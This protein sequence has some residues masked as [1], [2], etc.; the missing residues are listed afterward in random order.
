MLETIDNLEGV[1]RAIDLTSGAQR[2]A[3]TPPLRP[4]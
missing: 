4:S 2:Y 3:M 1:V